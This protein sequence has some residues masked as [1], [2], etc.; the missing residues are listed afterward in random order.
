MWVSSIK[1][2]LECKSLG[3][4]VKEYRRSL[5]LLSHLPTAGEKRESCQYLYKETV[6]TSW[7]ASTGDRYVPHE[8]TSRENEACQNSQ[9]KHKKSS[10]A[11]LTNTWW[12]TAAVVRWKL[13][14]SNMVWY[15]L[16]WYDICFETWY[17]YIWNDSIYVICDVID[18]IRYI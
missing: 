18:W 7:Q 14:M 2:S 17:D 3:F 11:V 9:V 16:V 5:W 10:A 15:D 12:Q 13:L 8:R 6:P 1:Q 4:V